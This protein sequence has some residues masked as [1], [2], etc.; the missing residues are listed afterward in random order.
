[1]MEIV[2]LYGLPTGP[3]RGA[4]PT[5]AVPMFEFPRARIMPGRQLG[6]A[7]LGV[8]AALPEGG[9][10]FFS[11]EVWLRLLDELMLSRADPGVL[12]RNILVRYAD[13]PALVGRRFTLQGVRFRGTGYCAPAPWMDA[14]LWPGT[15]RLLRE[16]KAGGLHARA[17]T[18]GVLVCDA[19]PNFT[20]H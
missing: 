1:M 5:G 14:A 3:R 8:Q 6:A 9:I 13:L 17:L 18:G 2:R 10:T 11:E 15:F 19:E 16:W 7:R 12:R 4:Q 20:F